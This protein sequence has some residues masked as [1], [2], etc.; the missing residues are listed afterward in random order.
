M[1][2]LR[3]FANNIFSNYFQR[4]F[5]GVLQI[6]FFFE[7][8]FNGVFTGFLRGFANIFFWKY[9]QRGFYG[10][11]TGFRKEFFI[12]CLEYSFLRG[13]YGVFTGFGEIKKLFFQFLR[14]FYGVFTGFG[15]KMYKISH[16]EKHDSRQILSR[17]CVWWQKSNI[18]VVFFVEKACCSL[19]IF[20]SHTEKRHPSGR[21]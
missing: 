7:N 13:F 2:F 21:G 8:I 3:G 10:V 15:M 4:G 6:F 12:K 17:K 11:F 18:S 14:G 19:F 20:I 5:Y 9:F 1:G 16:F